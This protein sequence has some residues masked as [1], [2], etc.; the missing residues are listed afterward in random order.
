MRNADSWEKATKEYYKINT[1]VLM[2]WGAEDWS[3]PEERK[4][5][6]EKVPNSR[7][8]TVERGRHFLPLDAPQAVIDHI[9]RFQA[10]AVD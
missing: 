1:P 10:T 8:V 4:R 6:G 7:T 3:A 2:V 9:R 5:D